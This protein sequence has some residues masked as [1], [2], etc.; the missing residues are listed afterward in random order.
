MKQG[1][2]L[3]RRMTKVHPLSNP[4]CV[5]CGAIKTPK[6]RLNGEL[7]SPYLVM[8]RKTCGR[9]TDCYHEFISGAGNG[10]YKGYMPTCKQCGKRVSYN[11]A[12]EMKAGIRHQYCREC[13]LPKMV[14]QKTGVYPEHL[15]P[16]GFKKG[17]N[18]IE[19]HKSDCVCV[20]HR[21]QY[22]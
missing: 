20:V 19:S 2:R 4:G 5:V 16:F 21:R 9:D 1:K 13:W 6:I 7:E 10:N 8:R 3:G 12:V 18:G 14:A 22:Q 15:K 17:R 11:S